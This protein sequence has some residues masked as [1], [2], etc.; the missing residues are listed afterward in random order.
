MGGVLGLLYARCLGLAS[1]LLYVIVGMAAM[2]AATSKSLLT[3]IALVAETVGPSFIIFTVIPA[4]ISYFLTGNRPF[5]KS[6][7]SQRVEPTSFNDSL[8]RYSSRANKKI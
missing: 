3:S 8:Y 7:R 6:Q 4:A 1:V 5:Y 2:L